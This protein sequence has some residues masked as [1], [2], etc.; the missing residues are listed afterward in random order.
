[1]G[2]WV[3]DADTLARSRF[4]V[5]ALSET[6]ACLTTLDNGL[7]AHPG[8]RLWLAAHRPAYQRL[9]AGDTVT[10]RLLRAALRPHWTADFLSPVPPPDGGATF[11]EELARVRATD[12]A[13]ARDH[14]ATA[15]GGRLPAALCRNDLPERAAGL[16]EWVWRETVLP[17]W[18][19]RRRLFEADILAR[20]RQLSTGGWAAA[21]DDIRPGMRWLGDGRL[22]VNPRDYPPRELSGARLLFVPVSGRNGWVAW[23]DPQLYAAVYPCAGA[24]AGTD[25]AAA[26][27]ALGRLL[28]TGRA[29][30]LVL[31][32]TPRSTTQLVAL[33][34][35]GLGSVGRHLK[36]LLDAGLVRRRRA[37]RSVLYYRTGAG[38]VLVTARS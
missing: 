32:G 15:L 34:G 36:V 37:G 20:T 9:L 27:A 38:D 4:L 24:L 29:A 5:S 28:G 2:L 8:E 26:P 12:P 23:Q 25:G 30:V 33:T 18:P 10:A 11:D 19:R 31:L 13:A 3:I 17:Y 22:Q 16:L 35:Q 7:A 14:L 1:M 21:L 6:V